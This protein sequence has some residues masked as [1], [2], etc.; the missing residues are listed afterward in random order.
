MEYKRTLEEDYQLGKK[1][2]AKF[3]ANKERFDL[4]P[5]YPLWELVR[6]YTYG[7]QKYDPENWRK[8]MPW[9]KLFS[10]CLRHLYKW[11]MGEDCDKESG[12]HHLAHAA[13]QCFAL[14]EYQRLKV[15]KDDRMDKD[16]ITWM[17]ENNKIKGERP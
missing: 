7:A 8:G 16:C 10:A 15:G 6:I 13:F 17:N 12:L 5:S 2:G 14:M 1:E 3:D 4:L 11:W 9:G